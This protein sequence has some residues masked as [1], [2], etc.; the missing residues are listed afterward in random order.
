MLLEGMS[1][2]RVI[3]PDALAL[4]INH[5]DRLLKEMKYLIRAIHFLRRRN[6]GNPELLV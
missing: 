4:G 3:A 6:D 5:E 1:N 2:Q